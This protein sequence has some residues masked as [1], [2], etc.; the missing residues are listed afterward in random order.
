MG[1]QRV[2]HDGATSLHFTSHARGPLPTFPLSLGDFRK[3]SLLRADKKAECFLDFTEQSIPPI[4]TQDKAE[5]EAV[6][7]K[8]CKFILTIFLRFHLKY[9][10]DEQ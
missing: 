3:P 4:K 6:C 2:R 10:L 9:P 5:F 8:E 7:L 1:S